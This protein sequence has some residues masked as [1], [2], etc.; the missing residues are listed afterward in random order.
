[1][2]RISPKASNLINY[3]DR[4]IRFYA[5]NYNALPQEMICTISRDD[6]VILHTYLLDKGYYNCFTEIDDKRQICI[7]GVI[8]Y[9]SIDIK[10][11]EIILSSKKEKIK[12][13]HY[14][15]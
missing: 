12:I 2:Q 7:H 14:E 1:M 15:Q 13:E 11:K 10:P 6:Y 3:Y 9:S 8:F 5:G 4:A